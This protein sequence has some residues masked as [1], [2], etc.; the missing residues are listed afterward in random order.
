VDSR[1]GRDGADGLTSEGAGREVPGSEHPEGRRAEGLNHRPNQDNGFQEST[2]QIVVTW[3]SALLL[4]AVVSYLVWE[5]TRPPE[6]A[7]FEGGIE[8]VRE[9]GGRFHAAVSV[10]NDGGR[11]VQSLG[12]ALELRS[13]DQ[14]VERAGAVLDWLPEGSTRRLVLIL[15][16]DP[17]V[18][19]SELLFEGYLVP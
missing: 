19:E 12:V 4:L 13:G 14:V 16:H 3:L 8:A 15:E 17:S 10:A 18:Y 7:R 2:L 6:D 1:A 9:V 5:G 11:S